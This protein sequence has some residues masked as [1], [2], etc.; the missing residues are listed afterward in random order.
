[1]KSY[2][3]ISLF[4]LLALLVMVGLA[5]PDTAA[6]EDF[7]P[8]IMDIAAADDRFD[9][10]EAAVKAANLADA[11]A[12]PGKL[13]VFAPTDDAFAKLPASLINELLADPEGDL[14]QILLYHVAP[15]SLGSSDVLGMTSISTLQGGELAVSLRDGLP[16]VDDS[17][18][19]ITDIQAKNG[20]IHVID[21]VLVPDVSLPA[22]PV[23]EEEAAPAVTGSIVDIAVANG[24][25]ETLVQAVT[26][27]GLASTLDG[28][29]NFTVFAPTDAAFAALPAGTVEALLADPTGE[30]KTILLYHVV[31]DSL[32]G[33]QIATDDYIPTLEGRPL[34]VNLDGN[35]IVDIS[36]AHIVMRDIQAANG[37]IHVIDAVMIP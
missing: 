24:N 35:N 9:T 13:T 5:A 30:L 26:A 11:L 19:I 31:G 7:V 2:V 29:G 17:Q 10:L 21:T 3:M 28:P 8:N 34:V 27:A 18:I 32:S 14:T 6:A 20:I 23:V 1:M 22:T 36:G 16:Y 37:V 4:A 33:D 12:A 15:G 25:F